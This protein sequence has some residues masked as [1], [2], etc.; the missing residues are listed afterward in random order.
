MLLTL[1]ERP[2]IDQSRLG[3]ATGIDLAT[4]A[5]LVHRMEQRGLLARRVDPANRRR[6]LLTLTEDGTRALQ[7]LDPL[8]AAVDESVLSG[9]PARDRTALLRALRWVSDPGNY[10]S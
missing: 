8:A 5:T 3:E 7:R 2:D 10:G 6:K 4:L 9:L 1:R